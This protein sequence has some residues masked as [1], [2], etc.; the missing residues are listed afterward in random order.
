M[1][2]AVASGKGG[3]GKTTVAT[4]LA[5][6]VNDRPVQLIDCDVE[7]PNAHIFMKPRIAKS[8]VVCVPVP[9]VDESKCTR[10]GK[11]AEVCQFNALAVL[12]DRVMIFPN[13]CG[14]CGACK[15]VCPENAIS[16]KKREVGVIEFGSSN[17][18]KFSHGKLNIGEA[19]ATPVIRELKRR[20]GRECETIIDVPPGTSC[21]VIESVRGSDFVLLVTEPTPFGLNDLELAVEMLRALNLP[22][23]VV[24]NRSG[25]GDSG[26]DKYCQ[27]QKIPI[28]L[29]IPFDRR[30]AEGYS[31]GIR[32]IEIQPEW[33]TRLREVYQYARAHARKR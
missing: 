23:A 10:C 5:L 18:I 2:I 31:Y 19:M 14:G 4:S 21:P 11:C 20:I 17:G 24:I 32:L 28:I 3:T 16:E 27:K 9:V 15:L 33:R 29:R 7:E 22:H 12:K 6:A 1:I 30:I 8:E 13:L 26:V 25:T